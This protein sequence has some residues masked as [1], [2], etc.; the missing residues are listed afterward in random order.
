MKLGQIFSHNPHRVTI[1][2]I[3][4]FTFLVLI[5]K[6][7]SPG[8]SYFIKFQDFQKAVYSRNWEQAKRLEKNLNPL[9][10]QSL[11]EE[12]YPEFLLQKIKQLE[13]ISPK[14]V[15]NQIAI[16]RLYFKLQQVE[17]AKSALRVASKIDPLRED[18]K[19]IISSL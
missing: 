9:D 3:L 13:S 8:N 7:F 11:K 1:S 12:N 10:I 17:A 18:L 16:S 15:E 5:N 19:A 14:T 2:L 6:N 4:S